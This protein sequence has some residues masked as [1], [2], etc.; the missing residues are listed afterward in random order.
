MPSNVLNAIMRTAD[1]VGKAHGLASVIVLTPLLFA[2]VPLAPSTK[3]PSIITAVPL[4]TWPQFT[5]PVTVTALAPLAT[6]TLADSKNADI[7][8]PR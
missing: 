8:N 3:M 4:T 1:L 6:D 5:L 2:A 7:L